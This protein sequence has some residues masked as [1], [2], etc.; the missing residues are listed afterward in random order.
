[1]P[2]NSSW[3]LKKPLKNRLAKASVGVNPELPA[4]LA[5]GDKIG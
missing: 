2:R 3:R 4:Q 1:M 5:H